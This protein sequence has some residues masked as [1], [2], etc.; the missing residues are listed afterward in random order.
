MLEIISAVQ[1]PHYKKEVEALEHI[2]KGQQVWTTHRMKG[3]ALVQPGEKEV[4]GELFSL[5]LP[6]RRL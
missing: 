3:A 5:H 2:L 6:E 1:I 4:Q